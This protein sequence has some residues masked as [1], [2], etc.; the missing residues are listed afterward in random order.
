M[1]RTFYINIAGWRKKNW[2]ADYC[3]SENVPYIS[4]DGVPQYTATC[5]TCNTMLNFEFITKLL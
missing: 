2:I 3:W 4:Q 1:S 5:L